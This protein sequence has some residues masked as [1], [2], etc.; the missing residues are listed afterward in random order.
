MTVTLH[1]TH[2]TL[3]NFAKLPGLLTKEKIILSNSKLVFAIQLAKSLSMTAVKVTN[4]TRLDA[5]H[6]LMF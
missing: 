5:D 1:E 2:T 4:Q 6:V 3:I